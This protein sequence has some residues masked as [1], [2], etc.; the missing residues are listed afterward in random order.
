MVHSQW[1]NIRFQFQKAICQFENSSLGKC[2]LINFYCQWEGAMADCCRIGMKLLS[3]EFDYKRASLQAAVA[4]KSQFNLILKYWGRVKKHAKVFNNTNLSVQVI[5]APATQHIFTF[6]F[7]YMLWHL[8]HK[9]IFFGT[10]NFISPSIYGL[11]YFPR[12]TLN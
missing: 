8:T 9:Y 4:C 1:K 10:A 11:I 3:I 6:I 2:Y 7:Y 12:S 5:K